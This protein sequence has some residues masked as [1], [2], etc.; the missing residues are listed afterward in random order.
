MQ[1]DLFSAGATAASPT[2][3]LPLDTQQ[4]S[5]WQSLLHEHQAP[6]F[7]GEQ[8]GS[9][10]TDLFTTHTTDPAAAIDP[11]ELTPLP[12]NFWRWPDSPHRGAAIYFV[13]DRP[14]ALEQPLLLYVGETLAA[15]RR[16]KGEHDC[17][18]YWL[19]TAKRYSVVVC[20]I[21]SVSVSGRMH[22]RTPGQDAL[23]NRL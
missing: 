13:L 23:S 17:K 21:S 16:W 11:T 2:P 9:H 15:D 12:L 19:P 22:P 6:L 10:Q 8:R 5:R 1:G 20:P 3:E 14:P 7:R 4:L 18:A